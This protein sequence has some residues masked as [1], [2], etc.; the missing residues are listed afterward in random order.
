MANVLPDYLLARAAALLD[1]RLYDYTFLP[2]VSK[3]AE[4]KVKWISPDWN[5]FMVHVY[6][7]RSPISHFAFDQG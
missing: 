4:S 7:G 5:S 3:K 2:L 1:F 6:V